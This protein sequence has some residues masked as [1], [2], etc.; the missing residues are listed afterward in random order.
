MGERILAVAIGALVFG[1]TAC[2]T[3]VE[4]DLEKKI[5][6]NY[7]QEIGQPTKSVACPSTADDVK[8]GSEVDCKVTP[9]KGTPVTVRATFINDDLDFNLEIVGD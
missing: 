5:A 3:G 9:A 8:N 6:E 4:E 2:G 1:L 7:E